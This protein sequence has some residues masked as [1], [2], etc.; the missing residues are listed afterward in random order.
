MATYSFI[1][2]GCSLDGPGVNLELGYGAAVAEEGIAVERTEDANTMNIGADGEPM[3]SLH[4][5]HS[6]T[7]R[8]RLQK[9]SPANAYLMSA[10]NLQRTSGANHGRNTIVVRDFQRGDIVSCTTV[11]FTGPP[12]LVWGKQGNMQE[13]TFHAGRV[14]YNLGTGTPPAPF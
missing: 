3:H 4:A 1:D 9:T 13:W 7:V 8:I 11:A 6:G 14:S 10:W 2:V 12:A 5:G